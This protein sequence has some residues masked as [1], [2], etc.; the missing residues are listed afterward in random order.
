[1]A[2]KAPG[3]VV[4]WVEAKN[5]YIQTASR[6]VAANRGFHQNIGRIFKK[7]FSKVEGTRG[8]YVLN[9]SICHEE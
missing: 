8:Y 2:A 1:M 5:A 4:R 9:D 7:Y 6:Y 3:G